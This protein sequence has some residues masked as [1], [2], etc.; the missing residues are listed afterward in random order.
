LAQSQLHSKDNNNQVEIIEPVDPINSTNS[1]LPNQQ[2]TNNVIPSAL[3]VVTN[4]SISRRNSVIHTKSS[5]N[6]KPFETVIDNLSDSMDIDEVNKLIPKR[7][8]I[9]N[10]D[11]SNL[12][13][14][15]KSK[16]TSR[17]QS[18]SNHSLISTND[19]ISKKPNKLLV[20]HSNYYDTKHP[21][22]LDPQK[23]PFIGKQTPISQVINNA[24]FKLMKLVNVN[25]DR[26]QT[27]EISDVLYKRI[28]PLI[29]VRLNE[30]FKANKQ[31]LLDS[32]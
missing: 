4:Q 22:P 13:N 8:K 24:L 28:K 29:I 14:I 10:R 11:Q 18:S 2:T 1:R 15:K 25:C 30:L 26:T 31:A 23:L 3:S 5:L 9:L 27:F 6:T 12:E 7:K 32:L 20:H 19:S 16:T 21:I 17:N